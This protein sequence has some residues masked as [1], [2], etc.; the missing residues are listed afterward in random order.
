MF[1]GSLC[2]SRFSRIL[3][4]LSMSQRHLDVVAVNKFWQKVD[5]FMKAK[6][7]ELVSSV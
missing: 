7:P 4:Q 1:G 2:F 3:C 5:I 6:R